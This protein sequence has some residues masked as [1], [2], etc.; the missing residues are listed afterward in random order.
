MPE[1][2]RNRS[3]GCALA[4]EEFQRLSVIC[5]ALQLPV[6]EILMIGVRRCERRLAEEQRRQRRNGR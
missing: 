4:D 5:A 1:R 2:Y 3:V 6:R